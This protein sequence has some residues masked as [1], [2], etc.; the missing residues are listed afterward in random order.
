MKLG[1][2]EQRAS[3][4]ECGWRPNMSAYTAA[5]VEDAANNLLELHIEGACSCV[6]HDASDDVAPAL[7]A[8]VRHLAMA[9][10][11]VRIVCADGVAAGRFRVLLSD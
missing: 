7:L 3:S 8:C 2:F 4:D 6:A 11:P 1:G 10:L 9:G 5:S